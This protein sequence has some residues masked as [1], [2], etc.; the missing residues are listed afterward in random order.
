M[1]IEN[2]KIN[3]EYKTIVPR[4]T[5]GEYEALKEDI[6]KNG[7]TSPIFVNKD[8]VLID[9]YTRIKIAKELGIKEIKSIVL[10]FK[11]PEEEIIK[12]IEIN[13]H[14]RHLN[15]PQKAT[16]ALILLPLEEKLAKKRQKA[17]LPERGKRGF[18]K[19]QLKEPSV[20]ATL[21]P[22][23]KSRDVVAKNVGISGRTLQK[24]KKIVEAAKT[25]PKIEKAWEDAQKGKKS[26]SHVYR[27]VKQKE[28]QK[29]LKERPP[30]PKGI[31]EV[32]IADPPWKYQFAESSNREIE[33][34]YPTMEL[35]DICNLKLPN[36]KNSVLFLWVTS[37]KLEEGIEVL[38]SWGYTYKT[39]MVWVKNKIG[40]GYYAR[41][42]HEF[43]LI[44]VQGKIGVPEPEDRPN[45]VIEAPRTGHSKKPDIYQMIEKM[46]PNRKYLEMF[47]RNTRDNWD[48]WGNEI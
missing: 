5:E 12:V 26:I 3:K 13:L 36:I 41:S 31:Y 25:D 28:K 48:N 18:Q 16:L 7:I 20:V 45:S 8:N 33:N 23:K 2:V 11:Y 46:Y 15:I 10:T 29:A 19:I 30:L 4:P 38:N 35:K 44:G 32:I 9:G 22:H 6:K 43:L 27:K 34:Q 21:P 24:A 14:R 17:T 40:M 42:R 1:K 39:S 47:A 37:P